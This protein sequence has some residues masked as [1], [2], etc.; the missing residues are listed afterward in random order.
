M[1]TK[2]EKG[3]KRNNNNSTSTEKKDIPP[4]S[5]LNFTEQELLD[6]K[7]KEIFAW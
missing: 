6:L 1:P 3:G 2:K 7:V 5:K 4:P